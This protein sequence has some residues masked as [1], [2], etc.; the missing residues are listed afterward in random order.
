MRI[1]ENQSLK[2]YHTFGVDVKTRYLVEITNLAELRELVA[3]PWMEKQHIVLGGGANVV[4]TH[5]YPGLVIVMALKGIKVTHEDSKEVLVEALAGEDWNDFVIHCTQQGWHGL[6]NLVAIPGTVGA[7]PVQNVGA[8][9]SE[10]K[11]FI[12]Y[13][14]VLDI[15]TGEISIKRNY[16]CGFAYRDSAFKHQWKNNLWVVAVGFLLSKTFAPNIG[17]K[18]LNEA[19]QA[20]GIT[21]PTPLQLTDAITKVRWKKLPRPEECGSAGSFFKN[22]I[23]DFGTHL[24]LKEQFP[25]MVSFSYTEGTFK[26]AAGWLIEQCGWKGKSLGNAGVWEHQALVLCNRGGC[27]GEEILNLVEAVKKDVRE[28]FGVDL[29]PEA[30]LI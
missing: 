1:L 14:K 11:D 12:D 29:E 30:I 9:G 4:F 23:V 5:N 17:Y 22:P 28:K 25:E 24:R 7:S 3:S 2:S 27:S 13:V 19:L 8:Y 26:L 15:H 6:E 20:K 18:A 10:A 16:E 21:S